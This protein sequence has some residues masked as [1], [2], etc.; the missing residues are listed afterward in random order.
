[1]PHHA[2]KLPGIGAKPEQYPASRPETARGRGGE[3]IT[4]SG[5]KANR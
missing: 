4:G 1:M 5:F 3:R 2:R